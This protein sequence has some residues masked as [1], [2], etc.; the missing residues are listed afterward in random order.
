M[1]TFKYLNFFALLAIFSTNAQSDQSGQLYKATG[2]VKN[3][4]LLRVDAVSLTNKDSKAFC[5]YRFSRVKKSAS[6]LL[7]VKV[8]EK[9]FYLVAKAIDGGINSPINSR[10]FASEDNK[11][12]SDV[13][14]LRD[15]K[16]AYYCQFK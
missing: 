4:E 14:V 9:E 11:E 10:K 7:K 6:D 16:G 3:D 8:A 2:F 1:R 13:N 12:S 15:D 5:V